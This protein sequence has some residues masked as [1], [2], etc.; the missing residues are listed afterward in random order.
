MGCGM[1]LL[2][3]RFADLAMYIYDD[4]T[5]YDRLE[6]T[7]D[8]KMCFLITATALM[9][10]ADNYEFESVEKLNPESINFESGIDDFHELLE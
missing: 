9:R 1:A 4:Q 7:L 10:L 6:H 2:D 5:M 8:R 3:L